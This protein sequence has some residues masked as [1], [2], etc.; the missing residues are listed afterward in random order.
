MAD[1]GPR[2][3]GSARGVAAGKGRPRDPGWSRPV[4]RR[5]RRAST[6]PAHG[7]GPDSSCPATRGLGEPR[8]RCAR[9][10]RCWKATPAGRE[11]DPAIAPGPA[12]P[13]PPR[14]PLGRTLV[15][16]GAPQAR[17]PE[18]TEDTE[19]SAAALEAGGGSARA[20]AGRT[21]RAAGTR[22]QARCSAPARR[23]E[24]HPQ[25]RTLRGRRGARALRRRFRSSARGGATRGGCG[26]GRRRDRVCWHRPFR[27]ARGR[28][29]GEGDLGAKTR[30]REGWGRPRSE[31]GAFG[32][33]NGSGQ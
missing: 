3:R 33:R 14:W 17:S 32:P 10:G 31:R 29:H 25:M 7:G 19:S 13:R 21:L 24:G 23:P 18:D 15:P 16:A 4:P 1:R 30:R 8:P 12:T 11:K 22:N 6:V 2:G 27:V 28:P 5:I 9:R 20:Q 26:A